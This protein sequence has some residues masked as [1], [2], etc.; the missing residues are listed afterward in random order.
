MIPA[1]GLG[2]RFLPV[3]KVVPKALLPVLDT[4]AIQMVA[5][6]AAAAGIGSIAVVVPP[7]GDAIERLFR[8]DPALDSALRAS[9]RTHLADSL[10]QA[11]D[12]P[13]VVTVLQE[14]PG[15][16][17]SAVAEAADWIGGEPFALLLPDDLFWSDSP[18][19]GELMT[20]HDRLGSSVI[21]VRRVPD[22]LVPMLG[23]VDSEP[24][25]G[26]LHRIRAIV[27]KPT[28][29]SAPSNLAVVGRY[30]LAAGVLDSLE[31]TEPDAR[32]EVQIT[33]AIARLL[34][35]EA[36]YAYELPGRHID[37]GT[38]L[39]MLEAALHEAAGR[40]EIAPELARL[41]A[42]LSGVE[43]DVDSLM[44]RK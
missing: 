27:E 16:L 2:T 3:T 24:M 29:D 32:G 37:V 40:P 26:R 1:A 41:I 36:V 14:R 10:R 17:G 20:A 19:I 6:E 9:G 30:V 42:A 7:G 4:P 21:A 39:G 8:F 15:G 23:I 35:S 12:M 11:V 22:E 38:P 13:E 18:A 31:S 28:P 5:A 34:G 33:D 44:G 25:G 43:A